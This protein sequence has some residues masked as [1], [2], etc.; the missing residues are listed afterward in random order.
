MDL[1][2]FLADLASR[3][4]AAE[5]AELAQEAWELAEAE[6]ARVALAQRLVGARGME[7]GCVFSDGARL[8]GHVRE[9]GKNVLVLKDATRVHYVQVARIAAVTGLK[10]S[11][12]Q[13]VGVSAQRTLGMYA[14][15]LSR[16]RCRVIVKAAGLYVGQLVNVGADVLD[17]AADNGVVTVATRQVDYVTVP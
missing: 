12:C 14:R 11:A 8:V 4:E 15:Q 10:M 17:L 16:S 9:A 2:F 7:V 3:L 5:R 13:L 6:R 1:E